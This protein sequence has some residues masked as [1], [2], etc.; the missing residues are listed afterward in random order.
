MKHKINPTVDCVF[1]AILGCEENK[2]LL[3]HFLNAVLEPD[4]KIK[5]IVLNNPYNEREFVS[6]KLTVVDVK[7]T[8]EN[9]CHY[10][11]EI[12]LVLHAA[13]S[14]RML[15]TWSSLYHSQIKKGDDFD[16]LKP[17]ISIWILTENLF[18]NVDDFHLP[19]VLYNKKNKLVLNEDI[20]I[21]LLQL[22]KWQKPQVETEKERWIYLFKEGK[23]VD[24]DEPPEVLCTD[25]MRQAMETLDRFS[26]NA[27]NY[28]LY[29]NRL[30]ATLLENTYINEVARLKKEN[31]QAWQEK[32]QAWQEK[33]QERQ[34]KEQER[35]EKEQLQAKLNS[36]LLKLKEKGL[37]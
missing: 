29:Q 28:L 15:Y 30:E 6:D 21:H 23:N 25:E 4:S 19:F 24:V 13:I 10:Q 35:R 11:I 18:D 5:E 32:E 37:D 1:K 20:E 12:Q 33:E 31:V 9:K 27:D 7:A 34:E 14:A 16:K 36:L 17:V 8:D 3:I 26:E 2:N 22:P